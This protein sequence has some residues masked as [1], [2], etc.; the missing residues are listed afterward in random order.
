[1]NRQSNPCRDRKRNKELIEQ[2]ID[3]EGGSNEKKRFKQAVE[4]GAEE[5]ADKQYTVIIA[6][7]VAG[8]GKSSTLNSE[9]KEIMFKAQIPTEPKEVLQS[10]D[11]SDQTTVL[12][13]LSIE[14]QGRDPT[15]MLKTIENQEVRVVFAPQKHDW[16]KKDIVKALGCR[17]ALLI[18]VN[19]SS[20]SSD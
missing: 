17:H 6:F 10:V 18:E 20:S 8:S 9:W 16:A 4:V 11:S 12:D 2:Y 14:L 13:P 19:F 5:I 7:G 1:M 3:I 15:D